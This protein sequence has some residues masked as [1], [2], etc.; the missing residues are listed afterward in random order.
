MTIRREDLAAAAAL[1]LLQ[2]RQI[3]PL[4]VFLL[5][6]DV[7]SRRRALQAEREQ[8]QGGVF[9]FMTY[10]MGLVATITVALFALLFSSRGSQVG[11]GVMLLFLGAYASSAFSVAAWFRARG[12]SLRTRV[13]SLAAMASVPLT[14]FALQEVV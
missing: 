3:D 5:Q 10:A 1:G 11:F 2:Y 13:F 9:S 14:V 7:Y 4:L 8:R 6:R 12:Y